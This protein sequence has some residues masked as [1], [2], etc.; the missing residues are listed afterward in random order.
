[1]KVLLTLVF[2]AIFYFDSISQIKHTFEGAT[3]A[4]AK[5][6]PTIHKNRWYKFVNTDGIVYMHYFNENPIGIKKAL[7]LVKEICNNN[8]LDFDN[9][10][11][12]DSY[13]ASYIETI[14]D[15]EK[16]DLSISS[17]GSIIEKS[18]FKLNKSGKYSMLKIELEENNYIVV[19][20]NPK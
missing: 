16:M 4:S 1:M 12:D 3:L 19:V 15:F 14:T 18:W 11:K 8:N 17:G 9:P 13:L 2:I 6:T 20:V 10:D 7:D 5:S